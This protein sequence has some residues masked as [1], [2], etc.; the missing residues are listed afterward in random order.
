MNIEWGT[1]IINV[2]KADMTQIQSNPTSIYEMDI[3]DFRATLNDLSDDAEGM[4]FDTTHQ[5]VAPVSLGGVDLARV[6]EIINGYSITFED[7]QYAVNLIGANSNI[8]DKVNVNQVS[9]RSANSAG[10][11][12]SG[13]T[14][15][16]IVDAVWDEAISG[17]QTGG[18]TG[19][20]L[21]SSGGGTTPS[22]IADA[23]WDEAITGH[24]TAG[25]FG[26][27]VSKKLLTLAQWVG[28]KD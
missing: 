28:L 3:D 15:S 27:K 21:N 8:A 26:E 1:K 24:T 12:D 6:I 5:H 19:E 11:V 22:A 16:G 14:T 20:T 2:L 7:G 9:I 25:T 4:P 17:H 10:L 23:V 13:L 18:S